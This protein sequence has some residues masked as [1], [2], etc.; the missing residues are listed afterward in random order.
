MY[1]ESL[2]SPVYTY[3]SLLFP[4]HSY[5]FTQAALPLARPSWFD[6]FDAQGMLCYARD[7]RSTRS[8]HLCSNG[9][10]PSS[11]CIHT[12]LKTVILVLQDLKSTL[13]AFRLYSRCTLLAP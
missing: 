7:P 4:R 9:P 2:V 1:D 12:Q 5:I 6:S 13:F 11:H 3:P 10:L 8:F